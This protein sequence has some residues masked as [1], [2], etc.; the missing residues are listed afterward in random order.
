MTKIKATTY[1]NF[2]VKVLTDSVNFTF[3]GLSHQR[4]RIRLSLFR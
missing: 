1:E 2:K 4:G 3:Q